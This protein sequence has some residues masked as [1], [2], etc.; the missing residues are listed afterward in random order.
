MSIGG[1]S[2]SN[3]RSTSPGDFHII[4]DTTLVPEVVDCLYRSVYSYARSTRTHLL[5]NRTTMAK[6]K[7]DTEHSD[8]KLEIMDRA[9]TL[10]AEQGYGSVGISEVGSATGL[11]R[12]ALYY[13]IGSKEELLCDIMTAYM[14]NL[15]A[16]A[17]GLL[18]EVPDT[19]ERIDALS[20]D[21]IRTMFKSR[22]AMTVCFREVH[23]L[24]DEKR[25]GVLGL[26]GRYQQIWEQVFDEGAAARQCRPVTRLETKAMLGMY[27]YS[28]L[29]LRERTGST[30]QEVAEKFAGIVKRAVL[31]QT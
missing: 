8:T 22:S 15:I 2:T 25:A 10:F 12:G 24:G 23:S 18:F 16:N 4:R 14:Q 30:P 19:A 1:H 31:I 27:F 17:E 6:S 28:F 5:G 26:H 13:H 3:A 9:A 21:F 20:S 29:W 11:G 7:G